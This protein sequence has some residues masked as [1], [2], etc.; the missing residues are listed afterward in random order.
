MERCEQRT[1]GHPRPYWGAVSLR[2]LAMPKSA[3]RP[4]RRRTVEES[5][6]HL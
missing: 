3:L 6:F 2:S 5:C 1:I 4:D